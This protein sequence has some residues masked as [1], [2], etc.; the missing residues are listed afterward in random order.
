MVEG[1]AL[2]AAIGQSVLELDAITHSSATSACEEGADGAT[3]ACFAGLLCWLASLEWK[4]LSLSF[5][6]L[7]ASKSLGPWY[8]ASVT[9]T[10]QQKKEK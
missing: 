2:L 5:A 10:N 8:T 6:M 7:W 4:L 9:V 1:A 3:G